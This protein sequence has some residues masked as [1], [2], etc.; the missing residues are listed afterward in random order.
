MF[1]LHSGESSQQ[2]DKHRR[3]G[4]KATG[5]KE[6]ICRDSS[7]GGWRQLQIEAGGKEGRERRMGWV[8]M[9]GILFIRERL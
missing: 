5:Q 8:E 4:G 3:G 2:R 6:T 9:E 7:G 1:P